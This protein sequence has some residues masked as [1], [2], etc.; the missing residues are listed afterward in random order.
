MLRRYALIRQ[1]H[2]KIASVARP[3]PGWVGALPADGAEAPLGARGTARSATYDPHTA[4]PG[5]RRAHPCRPK[6]HD[7]PQLGRNALKGRGELRDQPP[8][9]RTRRR[10]DA[11][12]PTRAAPSGTTARS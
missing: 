2:P 3:P 12:A 8:T 10:K 7:C 5:C 6:R 11:A 4:P 1:I 9:T